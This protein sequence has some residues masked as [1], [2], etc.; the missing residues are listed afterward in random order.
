MRAL[1]RERGVVLLGIR[2]RMLG[3]RGIVS[4]GCISGMPVRSL[5]QL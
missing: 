1:S 2:C 3:T 4:V 5:Y